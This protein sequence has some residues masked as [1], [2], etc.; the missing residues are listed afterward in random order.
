V[1]ADAITRGEPGVD[2]APFAPGRW[3][4]PKGP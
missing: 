2:L 4:R 3:R 1:I